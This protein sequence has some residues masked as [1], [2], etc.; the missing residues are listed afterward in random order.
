MNTNIDILEPVGAMPT[1]VED[2]STSS[3]LSNSVTGKLPSA[4]D[5]K[6]LLGDV[7]KA[8]DGFNPEIHA[9]D[10]EGKPRFTLDGGYARKRGR[11]SG[12]KSAPQIVDGK[13][14]MTETPLIQQANFKAA[15]LG[16]VLMVTTSMQS[17]FGAQ[18]KPEKIEIETLTDSLEQYYAS[19]GIDDLPPGFV[20][21][22]AVSAY[23]LPRISHPETLTRWGKIKIALAPAYLKVRALIGR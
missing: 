12:A 11:K 4:T 7:I 15:A 2:A 22:F 20:L 6:D 5:S 18:W 17:L 23:S 1:V 8:Y 3:V 14:S 21:A 19:K 13:L 16:T 9:T 10:N